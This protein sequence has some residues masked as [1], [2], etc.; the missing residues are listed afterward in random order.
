M[1]KLP[2]SVKLAPKDLYMGLVGM[3]D[4]RMNHAEYSNQT[5][6]RLVSNVAK[7]VEDQLKPV[8]SEYFSKNKSL[9]GKIVRYARASKKARDELSKSLK[10]A[11]DAKALTRRTLPDC[12]YAAPKATPKNREL[13]LVEGDSAAGTAKN[14]R[15]KD[16]QEVVKLDGVIMN[17]YRNSIASVLSSEKLVRL[18]S[19][20]G[21]NFDSLKEGANRDQYSSLRIDKLILLPDADEDGHHIRVLVLA[22]IQKLMPRL[23]DEGRV[24]VVDAP[25]YSAYY[26]GKRYFGDS[27]K[28][29]LTQLPKSCK[30]IISRAKG[31]GEISATMLEHIAFNP[32]TRNILKVAPAKGKNLSYFESLVGSET[33]TRKELLGV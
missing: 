23:F 9:V 10:S 24:Y 14:A 21:Y 31:W 29:V 22:L 6:E 7:Q 4:Y 11:S 30:A 13:Y 32:E 19:C 26:N 20:I 17:A 33:S 2:K 16:Y 15:N 12:L 1:M 8:L 28:E 25:L 27:H 3:F 5:K 18:L